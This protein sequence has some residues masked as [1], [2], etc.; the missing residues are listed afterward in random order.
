LAR[1]P[2]RYRRATDALSRALVRTFAFDAKTL[3]ATV[4]LPPQLQK[5]E[6]MNEIATASVPRA[7]SGARAPGI[8]TEVIWA[9]AA[10]AVIGLVGGLDLFTP[11]DGDQALF[12]YTAQAID[13]GNALY[14]DVWDLKQPGVFW[15][16]WLAG[17]TFGFTMIGVR[18]FELAWLGAL[19]VAMMLC[20]RRYFSHAWMGSVAAIGA[21]A[22]YY[23]FAGS[24]E[25]TQVEMLVSL[26]MFLSVWL[27][28]RDY[29]SPYRRY[30]GWILAGALAAVCVVFKL[31][32][33]PI[34][35]FC[36]ALAVVD[37]ASDRR[38]G[39]ILRH[40]VVMIG[41]YA[42]GV[43]LILGAT[44]VALYAQ[45]ALEEMLW[46][47]FVLP[48]ESLEYAPME[49]P[50]GRLIRSMKWYA[51]CLW[52]W[53]IFAVV[54]LLRAFRR[55]EPALTRQLLAW[56]LFAIL[57]IFVQFNAFW[58]YHFFLLFVPGAILGA[59]GID[60]LVRRLTGPGTMRPL[61]PAALCLFFVLPAAGNLVPTFDRQAQAFYQAMFS[62]QRVGLE[63]YRRSIGKDYGWV[64][65]WFTPL[66]APDG[67][68][69]YVAGNPL[70]YLATQRRQAI[71]VHGWSWEMLPPS[72]WEALPSQLAASRPAYVFL[73][74]FYRRL[75]PETKPY[76]PQII[77]FLD[78]NYDVVWDDEQV[79]RLYR[80]RS[81]PPDTQ[82]PVATSPGPA[83]TPHL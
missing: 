22:S 51:V 11:F 71:P 15:F 14:V 79:G 5:V 36:V 9:L 49:A 38:V 6:S 19:A 1:D 12:L 47:S 2:A 46:A 17:K 25:L 30:L 76:G 80:R 18:M 40:G 39:S 44:C 58:R 21:I 34:F 55:D 54:P 57:L 81:P 3:S 16:Y 35:V 28:A 75:F 48:F 26:P 27:T 63:A 37:T 82:P 43:A 61:A 53:L 62:A 45:G 33:A 72:F 64:E 23:T 60:L 56:M 65:Q 70:V 13:A 52:P 20:L 8:V 42:A 74:R 50:V 4:A 10:L 59:R 68:P 69:I 67:E 78:D 73:A 24:E 31:P 41:C 77:R 32:Y 29:T 83:F 66:R 7:M